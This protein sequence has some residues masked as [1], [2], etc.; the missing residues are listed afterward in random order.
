MFI[1]PLHCFAKKIYTQ[2]FTHYYP[3]HVKSAM[4]NSIKNCYKKPKH[5]YCNRLNNFF[6][7]FHF[8][9]F[10]IDIFR[11]ICINTSLCIHIKVEFNIDQSF[12]RLFK[13]ECEIFFSYLQHL[14]IF[15][16]TFLNRVKLKSINVFL[17]PLS[18]T[19]KREKQQ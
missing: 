9:N 18:F 16:C 14:R 15:P 12:V 17:Y 1:A 10:H 7:K 2:F 19:S 3:L 13:C 4:K 5:F 6:C 8:V 11:W